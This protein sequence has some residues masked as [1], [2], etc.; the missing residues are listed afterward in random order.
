MTVRLCR[1]K[2]PLQKVVNGF[3]WIQRLASLAIRIKRKKGKFIN[4]NDT[5]CKQ[6]DLTSKLTSYKGYPKVHSCKKTTTTALLPIKRVRI[7]HFADTFYMNSLSLTP[8]SGAATCCSEYQQFYAYLPFCTLCAF[9][10]AWQQDRSKIRIPNIKYFIPCITQSFIFYGSPF[11]FLWCIFHPSW[12][13]IWENCELLS[14][15]VGLTDKDVCSTSVRT[16]WSMANLILV[17]KTFELQRMWII[18]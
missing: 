14:C 15:G 2:N 5:N 10:R 17:A 13:S 11:S 6:I 1:I 12:F 9:S 4:V 7:A 8:E 18:F 3:S 16:M